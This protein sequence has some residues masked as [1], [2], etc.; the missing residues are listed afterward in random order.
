MAFIATVP[1]AEAAGEARE[2]YTQQQRKYGFVP[3][4]AT[5]F[6]HRPHVMRLW[7]DLQ[8]GIR[9]DMDKRRFE[10]VTV[11]AA[12]AVGS[13][14]CSLA[15]GAALLQFYSSREVHAIVTEAEGSPLTDADI[16][17]MRF[18]RKIATR[19]SETTE[20][21]V[22]RLRQCGFADQEIFD[23][24]A[25]ATART[26]FAQLCEGLGAI[27]DHRYPDMDDELRRV[28]AVG[29]PLTCVEPQRL[30]LTDNRSVA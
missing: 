14:Y 23:I 24:A 8:Y 15:H 5:V 18:A 12:M 17:M 25:A 28:L 22:E 11:A 26:F 19:A 9:K 13:T 16:E 10:L 30:A 4:Y 27:G 1:A 20:A 7:A 29:R 21:D 2:M 6:S 3:H